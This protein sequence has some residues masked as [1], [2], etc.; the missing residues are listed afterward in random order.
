ML[1]QTL[2]GFS[3]VAENTQINNASGQMLKSQSLYFY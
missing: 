1:L 2:S 3:S